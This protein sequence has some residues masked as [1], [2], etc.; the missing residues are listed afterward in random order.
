MYRLPSAVCEVNLPTVPKPPPV[1][2]F[3][4]QTNET[5]SAPSCASGN[6]YT[7]QPG[8]TCRSI[9][10]ASSV[11]E[12]SIAVV[13][14]LWADCTRFTSNNET[15]TSLC[16]PLACETYEMAPDDNCWSVSDNHNIT[17]AQFLAYNPA[18]NLDC[19]NLANSSVV[20]VSSPDGTYVPDVLEG[21]DP[22]GGSPY[23]EDAVD[24]PGPVPFGTTAG[25][26][27]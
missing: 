14:D 17:F 24:A 19:S 27:G 12:G 15:F 5:A 18:V 3:P 20:C 6:T 2:V 16:L 21:V 10:Q 26:G 22:T 7:V 1:D 9:A 25:C 13:N 23:A 4:G 8:D 11:S